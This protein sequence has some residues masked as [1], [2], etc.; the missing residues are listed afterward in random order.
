MLQK[1]WAKVLR[2]GPHHQEERTDLSYVCVVCI[3]E[4]ILN[5]NTLKMKLGNSN[6]ETQCK[7]QTSRLGMCMGCGSK[8]S[9]CTE[10]LDVSSHV[11]T[12]MQTPVVRFLSL[13]I[14]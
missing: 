7:T 13:S 9:H 2:F 1:V 11:D 8:S 5:L 10:C 4:K 6:V 14:C 12:Y 3:L